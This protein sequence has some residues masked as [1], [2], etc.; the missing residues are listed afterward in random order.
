MAAM[1]SALSSRMV[2]KSGIDIHYLMIGVV[3]HSSG[4]SATNGRG[5]TGEGRFQSRYQI[6]TLLRQI[7]LG[8]RRRRNTHAID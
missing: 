2:T 3:A 8:D 4:R 7:A 5:F 6:D 1:R